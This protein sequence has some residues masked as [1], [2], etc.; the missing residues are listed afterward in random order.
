MRKIK[1]RGKRLASG[2]WVYGGYY[3]DD[4]YG[5]KQG[6]KHYIMVWNSTGLS[7]YEN[8][9]VDPETVGQFTGCSDKSDKGIWEDDIVKISK[10]HVIS[11]ES[12]TFIDQICYIQGSFY[13]TIAGKLSL[14]NLKGNEM[15]VIG[16]IHD[17]LELLEGWK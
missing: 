3:L 4:C 13:V 6:E 11:G 17:S 10:Q 8:V 16:N 5:N 1:F 9:Q 12:I 2:E 7:Y 14:L 15:E